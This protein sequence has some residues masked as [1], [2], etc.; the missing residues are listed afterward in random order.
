MVS[1]EIHSTSTGIRTQTVQPEANHFA[2]YKELNK[3]LNFSCRLY[4]GDCLDD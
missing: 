2:D 4:Q 3:V 1:E